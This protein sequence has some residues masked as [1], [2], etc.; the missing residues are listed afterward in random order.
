MRREGRGYGAAIVDLGYLSWRAVFGAEGKAVDRSALFDTVL[1]HI[2]DAMSW[3]RAVS[4]HIA[5]EGGRDHRRAVFP[6]YKKRRDDRDVDPS[7]REAVDYIEAAMIAV[8]PALG[9]TCWRADG[10]EA[11]D[12]IATLSNRL[13]MMPPFDGFGVSENVLVVSGDKDIFQLVIAADR[14]TGRGAVDFLRLGTRGR[15]DCFITAENWQDFSG[16]PPVPSARAA[17][18]AWQ[19][20]VGDSSDGYSGIRGVGK[21]GALEALTVYPDVLKRLREGL[22]LDK[23]SGRLLRALSRPEAINEAS[24]SYSM[25]ILRDNVEVKRVS[26]QDA[27]DIDAARWLLRSAGAVRA[28]DRADLA[29]LSNRAKPPDP[30]SARQIRRQRRRNVRG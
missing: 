9:A 4:M 22:P 30:P 21:K 11:D 15:G 28:A 14:W 23:L 19:T 1:C 8:A 20:L 7:V 5:L 12:V 25:A 3:N 17:W 29:L 26:A 10:W 2:L 13:S 6:D 27:E 18:I 24:L 16:V